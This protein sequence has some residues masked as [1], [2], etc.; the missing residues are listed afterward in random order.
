M[1]YVKLV[2]EGIYTKDMLNER[3]KAFVDGMEYIK[4]IVFTKDFFGEG[5]FDDSF[6]PTFAK[7]IKEIIDNAIVTMRDFT[8]IEIC[9]AIVELIDEDGED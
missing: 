4:D 9:E 6:S 7:I 5:D 2:E 8:H 3:D 1:D